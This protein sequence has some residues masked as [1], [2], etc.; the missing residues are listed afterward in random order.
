MAYVTDP[1]I[2]QYR[3]FLTDLTTVEKRSIVGLTEIARDTLRTQPYLAPS[4]A[5][6]ITTRILEVLGFPFIFSSNSLN[7]YFCIQIQILDWNSCQSIMSFVCLKAPP[8]H[9]LPSLYLMDSITKNIGEPFKSCFAATLPEVWDGWA[10]LILT[11]SEF[12]PSTVSTCLLNFYLKSFWLFSADIH[13]R[14]V[15]WRSY[16]AQGT[17]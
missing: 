12:W 4:L 17:G 15:L 11:R 16:T 13:E 2:V 9:K 8:Q 5:Q 1:L 10:Q 6:A 3:S 14:V 7:H